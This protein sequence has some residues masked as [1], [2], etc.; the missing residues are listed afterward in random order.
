MNAKRN[1]VGLVTLLS[2]AGAPILA[3]EDD[4]PAGTPGEK[5]G[6]VEFRVEC[7]AEAQQEFNRAIALYHSFWF[8]PANKSFD[9]V[10]QLDPGC[11]LAHWGRALSAL[12]NPFAW[13]AP[14]KALQAGA[15]AMQKAEQVGARS[16]RERDY[17]AAL[18]KFYS[19]WDKTEHR[20]RALAWEAAMQQLA[21]RYADDVEAQ[22]F[23]ALALIA[24]ALP[25]DKTY[26]NQLKAAEILE[27][28]FEKHPDHPGAAHYLIHGYDYTELVQRGLPAARRYATIAPSAPHALHMPAHIFTRLGMWE[29]SIATNRVSA[30][31]ARKE[32][33]DTSMTIGSYNALH[34][35]DY[36]IYAHLQLGQDGAARKLLDE[37]AA[38]QRID[39]GNFPG[40]YALAA[41]PARYALEHHD[42]NAAAKLKLHP[43]SL[44]WQQF[45]QC[46]AIT[47]YARALGKARLGDGA[48]ART[49]IDRLRELHA[50]MLKNNANYWAQ[51]T[52]IQIS[53]ASAWLALAE[54]NPD[55]ALRLM[56][57]AIDLEA[58]TD[59]HPVTPGPL[60]PPREQ[61]ADMLLAL[62]KPGE[63]LAEYEKVQ[64]AEPN[65]LLA[66]YGAARAADA[67][68]DKTKS[69]DYYKQLLALTA[70]RDA[71]RPE[72]Q[73]AKERG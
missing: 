62:D 20:P 1:V 45:P 50:A 25:T 47:V 63:A 60:V 67:V 64:A 68:G 19:D 9:K 51:Q 28:F 36:M 27:P 24:N 54:K 29:E 16:E 59:K 2:L 61:L 43:E 57:S 52:Q 30:A 49:D 35:M 38:I 4:E 23:Y 46:E 12:G 39:I 72:I 71:E 58:A 8:D 22:I 31:A 34:A 73:R 33:N 11:G 7:N 13:P 3:H 32:L 69:R 55:E 6:T 18:G 10:A 65:R 44:P 21:S 15:G 42:W 48:G 41:M 40:A 14:A 53:A 56:H 37:I 70:K 26:K 17:I 5:L 66:I